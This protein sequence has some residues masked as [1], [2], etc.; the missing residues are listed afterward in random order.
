MCFERPFL[1]ICGYI[2]LGIFICNAGVNVLFFSAV[3]KVE[4]YLR[5]NE[6]FS[7]FLLTNSSLSPVT[8][9]QLMKARLNFQ[10]GYR[11]RY[12]APLKPSEFG[13]C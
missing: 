8:V 12:T 9:D 1:N 2:L 3:E 11:L 13:F 7:T 10:V 4:D 6:T 5:A